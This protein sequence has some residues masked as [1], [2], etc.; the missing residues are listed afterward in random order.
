MSINPAGCMRIMRIE[1]KT[2]IVDY[3]KGILG[4][5]LPYPQMVYLKFLL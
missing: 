1:D 2:L 5:A 4:T 3:F